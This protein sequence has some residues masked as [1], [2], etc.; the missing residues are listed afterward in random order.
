MK[1]YQLDDGEKKKK[2]FG[3]VKNGINIQFVD[4]LGEY[5]ARFK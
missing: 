2:K 1:F 3:S 4:V 5:N